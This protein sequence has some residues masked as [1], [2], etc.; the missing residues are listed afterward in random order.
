MKRRSLL[1]CLTSVATTGALLTATFLAVPSLRLDPPASRAVADPGVA[2]PTTTSPPASTRSPATTSPASPSSAPPETL[3]ETERN[4]LARAVSAAVTKISPKAQIGFTI[5]DRKAGET[6]TSL[7]ADVPLYTASVVKLLIAIDTMHEDD[8]WH[9]PD[10]DAAK[11]LTTMLSGSND[12]IASDL[13]VSDGGPV[14]VERMAELIGLHHTTPSTDTGQ[15]GMAKASANDIVSIYQYIDTDMPDD[16]RK[17]IMDALAKA[18]NPA[19]DGYPQYFG[20]P[21]GLPGMSWAIKQGWM[22]LKNALVLNTTGVVGPDSRYVVVL[23][24]QQSAGISNAT[25]RSAVTAGISAIASAL[26]ATA[27]PG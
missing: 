12:G 2:P 22:V 25:G 19:D 1:I 8:G 17:L 15:W 3:S 7:S 9:A 26:K 13:W 5:Y 4:Q 24:T 11:Q 14:I 27:K 23:M 10:T 16:E 20:I 18:K 6:L 21:D